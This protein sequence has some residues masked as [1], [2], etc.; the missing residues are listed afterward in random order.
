[1]SRTVP[2]GAR[3]EKTDLMVVRDGSDLVGIVALRVREDA[4][5]LDALACEPGADV[6][7][8]CTR[9]GGIRHHF[10]DESAFGFLQQR[11]SVRNRPTAFPRVAAR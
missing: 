4:I 6:V 8:A 1:M 2:L 9:F 5:R 11:Q 7:D 10:E 3:H